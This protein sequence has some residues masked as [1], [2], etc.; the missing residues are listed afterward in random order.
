[1]ARTRRERAARLG[2]AGVW[3][4]GMALSVR[5][6]IAARDPSEALGVLVAAYLGAWGL[7][8][9]LFPA[10]TT[11]TAAR[12]LIV[13]AS[14][15]LAVGGFEL[16]A[17]LG[18]I[19]YRDVFRTPTAAWRRHDHRADP[20][21]IYV[22]EGNVRE[23]RR[24]VGGELAGLSGA[25]P[26][27][28]YESDVNYDAQGFRNPKALARA[29]VVVVGDSFVEGLHVRD[30]E[31]M[32]ARLAALTGRSVANLGRSGD[33]PQ[34]ARL[35]LKRFG[36]PKRPE[37]AV[38]LFYEGNDLED[39][40]SYDAE[41]A[42]VAALGPISASRVSWERSFLRNALTFARRTWI[43][44]APTR[45]ARRFRGDL[46]GS[47][48]ILASADHHR[49]HDPEKLAKA[50]Q[51]IREAHAACDRAGVRLVVAF[52]PTK[53]R[54]YRELLRF[55][56]DSECA[57]WEPSDL[58]DRLRSVVES[59]PGAT[60][61]D[62]SPALRDSAAKG[63]SPYLADDTHWSAEGH[64]AAARA[65]ARVILSPPRPRNPPGLARR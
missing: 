63:S 3:L 15:A 42:A 11:T 19:D 46:H 65:L 17:W 41:K 37:V 16:P 33:G 2:V 47:P 35:V 55:P 23:R 53:L 62:L 29:D 26:A 49:S 12:F 54:A 48:V 43:K 9:F 64:A 20:D 56:P 30:P 39:A 27:T 7:A 38:W 31:L 50:A 58:P 36:L 4:G 24:F 21:L 32:T 28:V 1:M 13:T 6:G 22:R 59:L 57:R 10:R 14:L 40:A 18:R 25:G 5:L 52:V 51:A 8:F 34:Q 44:P 60:F 61:A 45:P